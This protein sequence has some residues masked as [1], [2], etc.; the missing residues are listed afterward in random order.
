MGGAATATDGRTELREEAV[1]VGTWCGE[2]QR[3]RDAG[4]R[5][6]TEPQAARQGGRDRERQ[7]GETRGAGTVSE[8][9]PKARAPRKAESSGGASP[10]PSPPVCQTALWS[11]GVVEVFKTSVPLPRSLPAVRATSPTRVRGSS[12]K[13]I[14]TGTLP[15]SNPRR[16]R[17]GDTGGRGVG[18]PLV[19]ARV[20]P[21][22]RRV[23][24]HSTPPTPPSPTS[25][26]QA[27]AARG[28]IRGGTGG[29][30][31][32]HLSQF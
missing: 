27:C 4:G 3:Q 13:G 23:S 31:G 6:W 26:L 7:R 24:C 2:R 1:R 11:L 32:P 12:W 16:K 21:R 8:R 5:G 17:E 9:G 20:A 28:P 25:H 10:S 29:G 15:S 22:A 30:R 19:A 18:P 14:R